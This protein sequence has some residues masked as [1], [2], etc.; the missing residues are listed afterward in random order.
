LANRI[1]RGRIHQHANAAHASSLLRADS[2]RPPRR[3]TNDSD[4][5]RRL[6]SSLE[7]KDDALPHRMEATERYGNEAERASDKKGEMPVSP[8][9]CVAAPLMALEASRLLFQKD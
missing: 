2:K 7:S 5:S 3:G 1:V 9:T 4:D 6:M 8:H